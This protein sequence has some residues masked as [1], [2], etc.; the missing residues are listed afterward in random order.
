MSRNWLTVVEKWFV[1]GQFC[2]LLFPQSIR[3]FK[4]QILFLFLDLVI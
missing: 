4:F 2:R 1:I 3:F